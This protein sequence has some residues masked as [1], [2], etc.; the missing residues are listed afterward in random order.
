MSNG[1]NTEKNKKV[2][3]R[4]KRRKEEERKNFNGFEI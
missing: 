4:S 3:D 1:I 2:K